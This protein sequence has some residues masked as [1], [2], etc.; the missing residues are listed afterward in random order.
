M[1]TRVNYPATMANCLS[2]FSDHKHCGHYVEYE[3]NGPNG[4][5]RC[6]CCRPED[7]NEFVTNPNFVGRKSIIYF[8]REFNEHKEEEVEEEQEEN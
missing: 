5:P 3:E 4:V 6:T 1:E 2:V 8:A 7:G